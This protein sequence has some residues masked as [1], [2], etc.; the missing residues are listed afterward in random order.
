MNLKKMIICSLLLAI[1]LLLHQI[2]PPL[3]F[4]MKPDFFINYDVYSPNNCKG[5]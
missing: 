3:L 1:G 2:S 4:G 5:L